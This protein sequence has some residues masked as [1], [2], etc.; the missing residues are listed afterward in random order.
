MINT[1][2]ISGY[3][4]IDGIEVLYIQEKTSS[5][6][7]K[8]TGI[9]STPVKGGGVSEDGCY[10]TTPNGEK[11]YSV[12]Y[13]MDI[14]GWRYRLEQGARILNL[15]T[16]TINNDNINLSDG[17]SYALSECKIEFY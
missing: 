5:N 8:V 4:K 1:N 16:G 6:F 9:A 14:S 17:R 15:L 13:H 7:E 10:I 2:D 12:V 3:I 11:F